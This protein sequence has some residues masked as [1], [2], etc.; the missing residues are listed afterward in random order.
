[1]RRVFRPHG[2]RPLARVILPLT[3]ATT[4]GNKVLV[5]VT[6]GILTV[7]VGVPFHKLKECTYSKCQYL[8]KNVGLAI[9]IEKVFFRTAVFEK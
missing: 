7:L 9:L 4:T 2:R 3:D 8:E 6:V 1:M 5:V